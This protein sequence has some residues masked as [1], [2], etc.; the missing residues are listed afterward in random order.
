MIFFGFLDNSCL[1]TFFGIFFQSQASILKTVWLLQLV[2]LS[3]K[4][5]SIDFSYFG[6]SSP[7][8]SKNLKIN[9]PNLKEWGNF[10]ISIFG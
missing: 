3:Q 2:L 7:T 9:H 6:F 8:L 1:G 10:L 4:Q 5:H